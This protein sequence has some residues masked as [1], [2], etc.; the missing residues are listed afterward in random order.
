M[1]YSMAEIIVSC[2][3][4]KQFPL[5]LSDF[6]YPGI[7]MVKSEINRSGNKRSTIEPVQII[8]LMNQFILSVLY[9]V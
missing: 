7:R 9:L 4:V 8:Y 3:L 2:V 6:L 5:S 1:G